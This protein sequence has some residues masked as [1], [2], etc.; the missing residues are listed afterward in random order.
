MNGSRKPVKLCRCL[1]YE[2]LL[3][4]TTYNRTC[5]ESTG[6]SISELGT[7]GGKRREGGAG[8]EGVRDRPGGEVV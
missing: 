2:T 7:G 6:K 1:M 5:M 4:G 8:T 3:V